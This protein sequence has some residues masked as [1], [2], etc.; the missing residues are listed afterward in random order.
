VRRRV[1]AGAFG[2][3]GG[4]PAEPPGAP[5]ELVERVDGEDR[6]APA[7]Q[8][9]DR[10]VVGPQVED[11]VAAAPQPADR[12]E[13]AP[14][15]TARWAAARGSALRAG[16]PHPSTATRPG[17]RA[18]RLPG[19]PRVRRL[20]GEA[21][22]R[23]RVCRARCRRAVVAMPGPGPPP[24]APAPARDPPDRPAPRRVLRASAGWSTGRGCDR[25]SP[26][27][28]DPA[29]SVI[30][31]EVAVPSGTHRNRPYRLPCGYSP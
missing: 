29:L 30:P 9:A 1:L 12:A 2:A 8:V 4:W 26:R 15:G 10:A 28:S 25:P 27:R 22:P 21:A 14:G 3:A 18:A 7:P 19:E 11:R 13:S 5:A 6:G 31:L 24:E 20:R 16:A 17:G 23:A